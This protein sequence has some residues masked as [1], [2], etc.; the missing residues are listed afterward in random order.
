MYCR[1][2]QEVRCQTSTNTGSPKLPTFEDAWNYV[3]HLPEPKTNDE[4]NNASVNQ[5]R[6]QHTILYVGNFGREEIMACL[7][8][9]DYCFAA[10]CCV[11]CPH[12][13]DPARQ[14]KGR[15]TPPVQIRASNGVED[16]N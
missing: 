6:A 7:R 3:A 15:P 2:K 11:D 16:E 9:G 1:A 10:V 4:L 8:D 5:V 14:D 12:Y 13:E